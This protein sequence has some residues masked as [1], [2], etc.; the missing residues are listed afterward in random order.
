MSG[1][2]DPR[3]AD[4]LKALLDSSVFRALGEK[5]FSAAAGLLTK[6]LMTAAGQ[7]IADMKALRDAVGETLFEAQLKSLTAHQAR[8]LARR[9][10][11]SVPDL[12]VSTAG[13]A[14]AWIRG[15][16]NGT[17]V[18]AAPTDPVKP[19]PPPADTPAPA[20]T[21]GASAYFGRKSFRTGN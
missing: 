8:L 7:T 3:P 17:S 6:K 19:E 2:A 12:E 9:L 20:T 18:P 11:K 5:E 4:A 13:A 15:L 16:M 21:G 1:E 10:D 14:C